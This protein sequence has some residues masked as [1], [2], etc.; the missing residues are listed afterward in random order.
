MVHFALAAACLFSVR[1]CCISS[2]CF[3]KVLIKYVL[4]YK[5]LFWKTL[6]FL[7]LIKFCT[8]PEQGI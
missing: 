5:T 6:K 7:F 3:W 4:K 8:V 1:L 2:V